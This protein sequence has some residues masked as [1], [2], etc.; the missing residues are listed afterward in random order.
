A[1]LRSTCRTNRESRASRPLG[2]SMRVSSSMR[3]RSSERVAIVPAPRVGAQR[4]AR[5]RYGNLRRPFPSD[6][7]CTFL[8]LRPVDDDA[9]VEVIP[10]FVVVDRL[11]R[12]HDL[13][14]LALAHK[15][16]D[17]RVIVLVRRHAVYIRVEAL[18]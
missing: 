12:I 14:G 7:L 17:R 6:A 10:L 8:V 1:R 5:G 2:R 13:D 4:H 11:L 9:L 18:A 3:P 15:A 16:P